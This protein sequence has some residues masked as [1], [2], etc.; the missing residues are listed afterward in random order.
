MTEV[1]EQKSLK[2]KFDDL[3]YAMHKLDS[4]GITDLSE[5]DTVVVLCDEIADNFK[6]CKTGGGF[7][8]DEIIRKELQ[9]NFS[10][11]YWEDV[12]VEVKGYCNIY[13]EVTLACN[14]N[15]FIKVTR[16]VHYNYIN[17]TAELTDDLEVETEVGTAYYLSVNE[18]HILD[19]ILDRLLGA[20]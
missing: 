8:T 11:Q 1:T 16:S 5:L 14:D 20:E 2:E 3:S 6:S 17:N 12:K 9:N 13:I 15:K 19:S 4:A 18:I 10:S 7:T